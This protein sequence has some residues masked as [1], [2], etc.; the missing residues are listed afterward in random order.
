MKKT[1]FLMALTALIGLSACSSQKNSKATTETKQNNNKQVKEKKMKVTEHS[2]LH[3]QMQLLLKRS[4]KSSDISVNVSDLTN[5]FPIHC[6]V[7][8]V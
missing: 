4:L 1:I 5:T 3:I 7:I 6:R 8:I 2:F